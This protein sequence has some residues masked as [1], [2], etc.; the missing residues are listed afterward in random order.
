MTRVCYPLVADNLTTGAADL[1]AVVEAERKR[2]RGPRR[3]SQAK[4]I[5]TAKRAGLDVV[6]LNADGSILT[7]KAEQ[8]EAA[9]V[10]PFDQ[11]RARHAG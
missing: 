11:W 2:K 5:E 7:G 3:K 1:A 6:A 4:M 8:Q 10:L 9:E